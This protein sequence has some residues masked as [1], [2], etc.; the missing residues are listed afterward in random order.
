[1]TLRPTILTPLLDLEGLLPMTI[2]NLRDMRLHPRKKRQGLL[3]LEQPTNVTRLVRHA[4]R[5]F[6]DRISG[7]LADVVKGEV[8]SAGVDLDTLTIIGP[9]IGRGDKDGLEDTEVV[10]RSIWSDRRACGKMQG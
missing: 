10:P 2:G 9:E 1:M 7:D 4:R 8:L 3:E 5:F 6:A